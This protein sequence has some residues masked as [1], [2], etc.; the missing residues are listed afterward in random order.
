VQSERKTWQDNTATIANDQR[1]T[2]FK[3]WASHGQSRKSR[4]RPTTTKTGSYQQPLIVPLNQ[5]GI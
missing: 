5:Q 1:K 3:D 4:L 2:S